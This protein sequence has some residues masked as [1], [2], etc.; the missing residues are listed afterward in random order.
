RCPVQHAVH[1]C[2]VL[3]TDPVGHEPPYSVLVGRLGQVGTPVED[4]FADK[5]LV[6]GPRPS[7][8]WPVPHPPTVVDD[9][10][11]RVHRV[12]KAARQ[13]ISDLLETEHDVLERITGRPSQSCNLRAAHR[14]RTRN[15]AMA[16][17]VT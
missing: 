12:G 11:Q 14:D 7:R 6:E 15:A 5:L 1:R 3:L 2:E 16:W 10:E 8:P 17:R 4:A 9:R 13:K